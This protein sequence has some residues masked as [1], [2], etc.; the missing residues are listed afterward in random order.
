MIQKHGIRFT[1]KEG[2]Y[3]IVF[4][5]LFA[6]LWFTSDDLRIYLALIVIYLSSGAFLKSKKII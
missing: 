5:A 3:N 4:I 1:W 6:L 2:I